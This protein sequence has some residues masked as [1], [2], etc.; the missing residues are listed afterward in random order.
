VPGDPALLYELVNSVDLRQFADGGPA[1]PHARKASGNFRG[2]GGVSREDPTR[3]KFGVCVR[4]VESALAIHGRVH[5]H[6]A[7][8]GRRAQ[9]D[10]A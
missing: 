2:E 5:R 3:Q 4:G 6:G 10:V 7:G 1:W 8:D 9:R